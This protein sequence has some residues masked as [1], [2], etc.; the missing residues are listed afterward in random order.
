[1]E[2]YLIV[3]ILFCWI[4]ETIEAVTCNPAKK[5]RYGQENHPEDY[6]VNH[7][8]CYDSE[9]G[10]FFSQENIPGFRVMKGGCSACLPNVTLAN[11]DILEC[12]RECLKR[13]DCNCFT[14]DLSSKQCVIKNVVCYG[15][16]ASDNKL[17][18]NRFASKYAIC[19]YADCPGND[20]TQ[21]NKNIEGCINSCENRAGCK[22]SVESTLISHTVPDATC[23]LKTVLCDFTDPAKAEL[24][25]SICIPGPAFPDW[26]INHDSTRAEIIDESVSTCKQV[27]IRDNFNLKIPWPTVGETVPDFNITIIGK[28][29][30]KCIDFPNGLT[31]SGVMAYVP[32]EFH[33]NPQF[34]GNFKTCTLVAADDSTE[35]K[36]FCTCGIDYCQAVHIRAFAANDVNME[37]CHYHF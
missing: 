8:G 5:I 15:T 30:R 9:F 27:G 25:M 26:F 34:M 14:Y 3:F 31:G 36:Y 1:M 13:P 21:E 35:C 22:V 20:L 33:S 17:T 32:H 29:L 12:S 4:Y 16:D 19:S 28:N 18:Y 6:C 24:H 23:L 10:C 7:G 11:L 2:F 37:I